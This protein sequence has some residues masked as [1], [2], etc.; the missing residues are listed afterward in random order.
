MIKIKRILSALS[1][2]AMI[3]VSACKKEDIKPAAT[4]SETS[5]DNTESKPA[6][7]NSNNTPA[8]TT[9]P[10]GSATVGA[11]ATIKT[12][13]NVPVYKESNT[14]NNAF[15]YQSE[16]TID[17][18]GAFKAYH[19]NSDLAL[20]PLSMAGYPGNW[21]AILTDANGEPIKQGPNDPAPGYYICMTS[22]E[23]PNLPV[24]D[25]R[26][27]VDAL[28][29]P[30]V[31]LPPSLAIAGGAKLGDFGAIYNQHNGML[32][33]VIYADAGPEDH[34]GECSVNAAHNVGLEL[35]NK[36][37]GA[38]NGITYIVFPGSG[39]GKKRTAAEI[40]DNGARLLNAWGGIG[41][42][43]TAFNN[44]I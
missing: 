25:P 22:L 7:S 14:G 32:T 44:S 21:W 18:D 1:L 41:K 33:Y 26:R 43:K 24:T 34:L 11:T 5:A 31:V 3:S 2:A 35:V 23:D 42:L 8:P 15:F 10:A 39:N 16:M 29:I 28:E 19:E 37:G 6:E 20:C 36:A 9:V 13:M 38:S 30:Y 17:A 40:S 12:V 4:A 27:Y